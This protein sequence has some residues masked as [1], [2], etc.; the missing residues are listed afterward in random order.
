M[1]EPSAQDIANA[2]L[3]ASIARRFAAEYAQAEAFAVSVFGL[4]G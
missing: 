4:V 2:E 1:T 3:R